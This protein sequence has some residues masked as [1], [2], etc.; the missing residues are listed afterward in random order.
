MVQEVIQEVI[1][2]EEMM[3]EVIIFYKLSN[4]SIKIVQG[5]TNYHISVEL[6]TH[7]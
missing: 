7:Y 2:E 1:Q 4:S 5:S 6:R 3:E